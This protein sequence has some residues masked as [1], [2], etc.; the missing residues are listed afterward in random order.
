MHA[1]TEFE[2]SSVGK[3]GFWHPAPLT[4]KEP[5]WRQSDFRTRL[6]LWITLLDQGAP[7]PVSAALI[8]LV[9]LP[10]WFAI[11]NYF[12]RNRRQA[13]S[14]ELNVKRWIIYNILHDVLGCGA[15][16]GPLGFKFDPKWP[17]EAWWYFL[18]PGTLT[19]PL[20]PKL[21][22]IRSRS[23]VALYVGYIISLLR[24]LRASKIGLK[25]VGPALGFLAALAPFDVMPFFASRGEH[26][27]YQ[28]VCLAFG[29]SQ[30]LFGCQ[31]VQLALWTGAGVSK[32]GPWFKYVVSF[33]VPNCVFLQ[34][35]V[36]QVRRTLLKDPPSDIRPNLLCTV[37]AH[38]G[39]VAEM[40]MGALL[41][42]RR[43]N[44]LGLLAVTGFHC[45]IISQTPF[46][47]VFEWN[48]YSILMGWYLY[49]NGLHVTKLSPALVVFLLTALVAVP[50]YGQLYPEK[51]PFLMAYRPYAGNWRF[52]W[53]VVAKSAVPRLKRLRTFGSPLVGER[54]MALLG[55]EP[56]YQEHIEYVMNGTMMIF[57]SYRPLPAVV[58]AL[59]SRHGRKI[60]DV[61]VLPHV[62]FEN[63]VLGWSLGIGWSLNRDIFR[64]SMQQVCSF[65]PGD[66]FFVQ[67]EPMGIAHREVR[68]RAVDVSSG[69]VVLRGRH[70]YSELESLQDPVSLVLQKQD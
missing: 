35:R 37:F 28:M 57:P 25:Q 62:P 51:V 53:C 36:P 27:V 47:S 50:V 65:E 4:I 26:Y 32:I 7:F 44:T 8:Y 18:T 30:W 16:S 66:C 14:S 40:L 21:G 63:Y 61:H 6:R 19:V 42:S 29:G 64:S 3:P 55:K 45:F 43:T 70:D 2:G 56:R 60:D 59:N 52:M 13:F 22:G 39:T 10:L 17:V 11:F 69:E 54:A 12:V 33:M 20:V 67:F 48:I 49:G 41:L 15:T 1:A 58:D 34:D 68:W 31:M 24:A 5:Q 9:K 46:A 38:S 23:T